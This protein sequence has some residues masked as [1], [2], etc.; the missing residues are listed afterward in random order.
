MKSLYI[1]SIVIAT[2][3]AYWSY[4]IYLAFYWPV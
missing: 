3:T 2:L 1:W 4:M